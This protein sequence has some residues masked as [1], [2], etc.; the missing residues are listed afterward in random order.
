M[1]LDAIDLEAAK[2][3]TDDRILSFVH[4]YVALHENQY[5]LQ[6]Q[7]V[8]DPVSGATF[9]KLAAGAKL[10]R[11]GRT[12]YFVSDATRRKFEMDTA[13]GDA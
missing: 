9:P 13:V 12:Y 1:P 5:Y 3:W 8:T 2:R 4:T 10:E 11:G 6:D 7:M